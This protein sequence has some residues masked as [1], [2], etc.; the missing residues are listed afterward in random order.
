[1]N[2]FG[3]LF[4]VR[5]IGAAAISN[6]F[7]IGCFQLHVEINVLVSNGINLSWKLLGGKLLTKLASRLSHQ[8]VLLGTA[9]EDARLEATRASW[10]DQ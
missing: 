4:T 3:N 7:G 1:M 6:A 9:F 8:S 2:N 10:V 5:T